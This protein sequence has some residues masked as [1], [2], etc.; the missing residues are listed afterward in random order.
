MMEEQHST[1]VLVVD[2]DRELRQL[3][4][5]ILEEE[6]YQVMEAPDGARAL[7][8]LRAAPDHLVAL[9]DLRMPVIS[10]EEL[11]QIVE[12]DDRLASA[13]A[14]VVITAHA[15]FISP[16]FVERLQRLHVPVVSKPFDMDA[17]LYAIERGADRFQHDGYER[18]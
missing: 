8:A 14:Y 17:L 7:N 2:D 15:R 1:R 6:G 16:E 4:R 10:G 13:H 3:L 12:D 9:V 11:L 18:R 5:I